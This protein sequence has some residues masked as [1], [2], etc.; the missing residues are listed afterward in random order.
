M[1]TKECVGCGFCCIEAPC[2]AAVR[3]YGPVRKCPSLS[4]DSKS[5]RYF[6]QL[7]LCPGSIGERYR[8]ELYAG[9]GCSS[10]LNSW[11]L[12]VKER[13]PKKGIDWNYRNPVS[14]EFQLFLSSLGRQFLTGDMIALT[15]AD[16]NEELLKI[17]YNESQAL[18]MCKL[19]GHYIENNRRNFMK[20]FMG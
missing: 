8:K 14:D 5:N 13:L 4:W 20:E 18:S 15:L 17:G 9:A 12:D 6:C 11:R 16:F 10:G 2:T 19:V 3:I 7:M 1:K